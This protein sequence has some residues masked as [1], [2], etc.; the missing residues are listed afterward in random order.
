MQ[1]FFIIRSPELK[2]S[3]KLREYLMS[4]DPGLWTIPEV[5]K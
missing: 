2:R 3:R 1:I 5:L 4:V